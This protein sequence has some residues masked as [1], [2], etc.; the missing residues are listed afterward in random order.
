VL[1][2]T[3]LDFFQAVCPI[4]SA[5]FSS[6]DFACVVPGIKSACLSISVCSKSKQVARVFTLSNNIPLPAVSP[7]SHG[8]RVSRVSRAESVLTFA[9]SD[10]SVCETGGARRITLCSN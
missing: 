3:L 6:G 8:V 2:Y 4:F 5:A 9:C 10:L 7:A 1:N